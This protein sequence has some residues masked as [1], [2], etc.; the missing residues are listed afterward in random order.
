[1]NS[2]KPSNSGTRTFHDVI[3]QK[4]LRVPIGG[5][6]Y[7]AALGNPVWTKMTMIRLSFLTDADSSLECE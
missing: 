4:N 7:D 2:R 1:M 6:N 5:P 3:P